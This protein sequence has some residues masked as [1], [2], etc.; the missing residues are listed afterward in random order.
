MAHYPENSLE[1]MESALRIGTPYV[2]CDIQCSADRRL[3]LYH[4]PSLRRTSG[5][6]GEIFDNRFKQLSNFSAG[7]EERFGNRFSAVSIPLLS[8]LVQLV[9]EYPDSSLLAEIKIECIV[10]FG[11]K[12]VMEQLFLELM[13][14]R[15]RC[16]VISLHYPALLFVREQRVH[17]RCGWVLDE[18]GANQQ[19]SAEQLS[20]E[21]LIG[22]R[23][24]LTPATQ[25]WPGPWQ[26]MVYEVNDPA[27]ALA[28][29][30]AGIELVETADA[31]SMLSHP[32]LMG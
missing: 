25:L 6:D 29:A 20:P 10:R 16:I 5:V 15:E 2:E 9:H 26:W 1:G 30:A 22:N 8:Q 32:L 13:P 21:L 18:Y 19:Q 23:D 12:P 4:D 27:Q 28:Y 11:L 7:G 31:L 14:I 3:V 17:Y 24:L